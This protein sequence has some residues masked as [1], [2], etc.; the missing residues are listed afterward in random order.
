MIIHRVEHGAELRNRIDVASVFFFFFFL[1]LVEFSRQS[2]L[3]II[4][5]WSD[6]FG[7]QAVDSV[8]RRK[9]RPSQVLAAPRNPPMPS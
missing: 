3:V 7:S 4:N 2:A 6:Y 9:L 5:D 1:L 8:E